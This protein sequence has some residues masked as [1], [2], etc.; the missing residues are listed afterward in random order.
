MKSCQKGV[1]SAGM[2]NKGKVWLVG[3]GPGDRELLT[4]KAIDVINLAD[5]I[6][7]DALISMEILC[8]LPQEAELINAGKRSSHH[9]MKQEDINKLLVEKALQGKHVVRL[10]GGDPFVFGRGGEELELLAK[11]DIP[12]EVIPGITSSIA[13]ATYNGIPVT[14]R[15]YTSSFHVI[16]GHKRQGQE[17]NIDFNSLVDINGTLVFL[18]GVASLE[19][20]CT[21]LINAGMNPDM[22]AAVLE[23]GTTC[24]Q[25]KVLASISKLKE[26]A[27]KNNIQ[28]PAIIIVGKVCALSDEFTWFEKL[29]LFG[30]QI[31]VTRPENSASKLAMRLK[32]LGAQ[33]IEFPTIKTVGIENNSESNRAHNLAVVSE[34]IDD[35]QA[36]NKQD[37][38]SFTSPRGVEHFF[39]ILRL[40]KKDIRHLLANKNLTFAVLGSGTYNALAKY[41]IYA[42]YM[43]NVYSAYD[44]GNVIAKNWKNGQGKDGTVYI[45]RAMEGS[46]DINKVFDKENITYKDIAVYRT[47][48]EKNSHITDK[49]YETFQNNEIDYVMFTSGST[50][51]GFVNALP[52]VD[53]TRINA[54]CIGAQTAKEAS[55]YGMNITISDKA[56]IDSM[57]DVV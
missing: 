7:Y 2:S 32:K 20:I 41:G 38:I 24:R 46:V 16:T 21:G 56:E 54:V 10:K 43:P 48:Y 15:D 45:F 9:L 17:L 26:T 31:V 50:V 19:A 1:K 36:S 44:L 52:K 35:I 40:L 5:V 25:R 30:K 12:Y 47:I 3:A 22:P 34:A 8:L 27:D 53:F 51:K 23:K 28:S 37:C 11:N 33:V 4:R 39:D 18:M 14:H 57:I 13:V 55:K 6:I 42:E 29:P 49:M